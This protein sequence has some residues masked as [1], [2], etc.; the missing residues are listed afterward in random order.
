MD[1]R[2]AVLSQLQLFAGLG[3]RELGEIAQ[4]TRRRRLRSGEVLFHKGD[5]GGDVYVI[6]SGRMKAF[7]TGPEGDDVVFRYM[8][9]G[10]VVG[11][12][13]AFVEGKRS[14]SNVAVEDCELLMI[15]RRELI[16]LLRRQPE[17]ALRLLGALA[18]RMILLSE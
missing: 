4:I 6:V 16:P 5:E 12:L 2:K 14:A 10:E 8:G 15:Q 9:A 17:I 7:A 3:E 13:G 11:E 1:D 18:T